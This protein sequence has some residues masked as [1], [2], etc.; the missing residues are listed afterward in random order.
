MRKVFVFAL[1]LVVCLSLCACGSKNTSTVDQTYYYT[2]KS[3]EEYLDEAI[4]VRVENALYDKISADFYTAD[5]ESCSYRIN[6]KETVGKNTVVYGTLTLRDKY[7]DT[8][9]SPYRTFEVVIDDY[10]RVTSCKINYK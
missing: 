1:T 5:P 8:I 9:S 2:T 10:W 7:G 6:K 3:L 4:E